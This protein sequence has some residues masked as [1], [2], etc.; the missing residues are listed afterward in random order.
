MKTL[1]FSIQKEKN[2]NFFKYSFIWQKPQNNKQ[3]IFQK[4]LK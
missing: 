3:N 2:Y 4:I 1:W